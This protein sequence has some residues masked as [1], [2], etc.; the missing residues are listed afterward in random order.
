MMNGPSSKPSR[1][2]APQSLARAPV[3]LA[4]LA[5][6]A[7]GPALAHAVASRPAGHRAMPYLALH[8]CLSSAQLALLLHLARPSSRGQGLDRTSIQVFWAASLIARLVL[9]PC[10]PFTTTDVGRYMWDGAVVLSGHDPFALAPNAPSLASLRAAWPLPADH[11]DVVGCYPPLAQALFAL[12]ALFGPAR[13]WLAWKTLVAIITALSARALLGACRDRASLALATLWLFHPLALVEAGVGAH[14]DALTASLSL[15]ALLDIERGRWTRAA[16]ALGTAVSLKLTPVVLC[17]ALW[18]RARPRWQWPLWCAVLPV[19]TLV[20]PWALGASLPGSL[21]LV[22]QHW[23]FGAPLWTAL[24]ARWP[25][26]DALI[27]PALAALGALIV[28]AQWLR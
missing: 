26:S 13:A 24:Y 25:T 4:L 1:E 10:S 28:L 23:S 15:W 20:M 3:T 9:I 17:V 11:H 12:C 7:L 2:A 5:L 8:L 27:R 21:P 14:L 18:P 16:L 6:L 22:A 19:T